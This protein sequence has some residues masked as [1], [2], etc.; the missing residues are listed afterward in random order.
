MQETRVWSLG[1]EDP[2]E[3]EV[4]T[5]RRILARRIPWTEEPGGLRSMGSQGVRLD[6]ETNTLTFKSNLNS[7]AVRRYLCFLR[8]VF[9][10][11]DGVDAWILVLEQRWLT[12]DVHACSVAQLCAALCAAMTYQSPLSME[13]FRQEYWSGLLFPP[14]RGSSP[15]RDGTR[16]SCV[17]C[18]TGRFFIRWTL[19]KPLAREDCAFVTTPEETVSEVE[20]DTLF[21]GAR[22]S[23]VGSTCTGPF[24]G[25]QSS[26]TRGG[27]MHVI[28]GDP[29][30]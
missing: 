28:L 15:P 11:W 1:Q 25:T 14:P 20:K 19:R 16:I 13:F 29:L 30:I 23:S 27:L 17:S 6:W 21:W 24:H 18:F 22:G 8:D 10:E 4:A 3:K 9:L 26:Q 12:R 5:H 2:L 7:E